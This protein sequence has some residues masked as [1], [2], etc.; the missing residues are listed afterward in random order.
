MKEGDVRLTRVPVCCPVSDAT[1]RMSATLFKSL[2]RFDDLVA[3]ASA[4]VV[5]LEAS[6]ASGQ[7]LG[8]VIDW[9]IAAKTGKLE[10]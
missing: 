5:V 3:S 2:I 7:G 9:M 8:G 4:P 1:N 10:G 6:A